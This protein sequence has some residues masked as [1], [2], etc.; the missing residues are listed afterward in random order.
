MERMNMFE[1][2]VLELPKDELEEAAK[3]ATKR[4]AKQ[5]KKELY[6]NMWK[7]IEKTRHLSL[8]IETDENGNVKLV[9]ET[10]ENGSV[11]LVDE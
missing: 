11:K 8:T 5:Q 6:P 4:D 7:D 9:D 3:R 1:H 10:D 2:M